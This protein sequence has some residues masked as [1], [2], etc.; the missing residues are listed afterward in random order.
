MADI[1]PHRVVFVVAESLIA[2]GGAAGAVQLASGTFTPPVSDLKPLGLSSWTLPGAWLFAT[3]A[4]PSGAAAWLAYRRS[5]AA[6][7]AVLVASG[8]L[9]LEL[10]VQVPFVGPSAL[11]AVFG[12]AAVGLGGLAVHAR[13]AGWRRGR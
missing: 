5:P 8:L 9:A 2:I 4:V 10:A 11:Q 3:V 1:H 13:R 7:E 6:P 12:T